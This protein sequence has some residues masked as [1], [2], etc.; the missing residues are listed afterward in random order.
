MSLIITITVAVL[1]AVFVRRQVINSL[2]E[3]EQTRELPEPKFRT[4]FGPTDEELLEAERIEA[5]RVA[6]LARQEDVNE[7]A[8]KLA[9]FDEV[10]Q[11]WANSSTKTSPAELLYQASQTESGESYWNTCES[12][13]TA[14]HAGELGSTSADDLAQ[15]LDS[16]FWL[17]PENERTPGVSFRLKEEIAGLRRGS[18]ESK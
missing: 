1:I 10:R 15:L 5:A 12:V 6:D 11:T 8:K 13:L 18:D 7:R 4:L 3:Q 16:H 17:L 14:W 9:K 2:A